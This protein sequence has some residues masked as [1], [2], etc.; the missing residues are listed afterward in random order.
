MKKPKTYRLS[1][2]AIAM[3]EELKK[4]REWNE[5]EIIEKAIDML[6][7]AELCIEPGERGKY[8]RIDGAVL[9]IANEPLN[10]V[11]L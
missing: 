9:T 5:T 1:P 3:L 7:F 8:R 10:P 4:E 11:S 2:A 6:N